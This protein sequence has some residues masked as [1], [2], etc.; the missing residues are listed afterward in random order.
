MGSGSSKTVSLKLRAIPGELYIKIVPLKE[1]SPHEKYM[2]NLLEELKR[3]ITEDGVLKDPLVAD[4]S[5]NLIIDGTHRALALEKLDIKYVP[6]QDFD[7]LDPK[8]KLYRW[9]RLYK[10]DIEIPREILNKVVG[11]KDYETRDLDKYALYI[12]HKGKTY[13]L[14]KK[15]RL[16]KITSI[17]EDLMRIMGETLDI[18]PTYI[19]E[20]EIYRYQY[21]MEKDLLLGYRRIDKVEVLEAHE[22]GVLLHHKATRHVP[23]H[24]IIN[25]NIPIEYLSDDSIDKAL[26]YLKG[27]SLEY[28]GEEVIINGRYYA[29]KVYRGVR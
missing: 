18:E 3:Q 24:R 1:L 9:F 15:L 19:S 2:D 25:I 29:E 6:I 20:D 7:Y 5:R 12:V 10:G 22:R 8:L 4:Y 13:I 28:I 17:I 11:I 14:Y 27:I 16:S 26:D 23:P 21:G